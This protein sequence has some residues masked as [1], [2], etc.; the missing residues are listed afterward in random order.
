MSALFDL[1][2]C[3]FEQGSSKSVRCGHFQAL[4]VV[5]VPTSFY[6]GA[7]PS[8]SKLPSEYTALLYHAY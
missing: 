6:H 7:G 3:Q 8:L 5:C 4:V 1:S 2:F